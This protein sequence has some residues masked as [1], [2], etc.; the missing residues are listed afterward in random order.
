MKLID[1]TGRIFG[2]LKVV[3]RNP[4]TYKHPHWDCICECGN[5][6]IVGGGHLPSGHTTSC[7][8]VNREISAAGQKIRATTHGMSKTGTWESWQAMKRRCD[9]PKNQDYKYYGGRGIGYCAEWRQFERFFADMGLRPEGATL[10]RKESDG[11]YEPG[12]CRW[13]DIFTQNQNK[14]PGG[15]RRAA[16]G[17]GGN[18]AA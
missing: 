13:A 1:L 7:G 18:N 4:G 16:P 14:R 8:C 15:N 9:D 11:N 6:A 17:Q 12:N 3:G 10:D 5:K 2:R